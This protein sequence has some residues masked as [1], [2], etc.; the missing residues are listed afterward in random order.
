MRRLWWVSLVLLVGCAAD[1]RSQ[2]ILDL[3]NT[4][5]GAYVLRWEYP[6]MRVVSPNPAHAAELARVQRE[7]RRPFE[8]NISQE[9][10]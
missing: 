2:G 7:P 9:V 5:L 4:R 8:W 1:W 6:D 10:W 3:W